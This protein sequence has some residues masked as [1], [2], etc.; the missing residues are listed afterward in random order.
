MLFRPARAISDNPL[1][2]LWHAAHGRLP[3]WI[4][5]NDGEIAWI[6][7]D[8]RGVQWLD[9]IQLP[10]KPQHLRYI[11]QPRFEIRFDTGTHETYQLLADETLDALTDPR[12]VRELVS[13]MRQ[14]VRLSGGEGMVEFAAISEKIQRIG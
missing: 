10:K 1:H 6:K 9:R 12:N 13:M 5:G 4:N 3:D 14:G 2:A 8:H 7:R 11:L